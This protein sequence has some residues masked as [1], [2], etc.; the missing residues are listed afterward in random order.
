[1][2]VQCRAM[3]IKAKSKGQKAKGKKLDC[4]DGKGVPQHV[5]GDIAAD[6]G[7]AGHTLEHALEV[8][9]S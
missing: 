1:M 7:A 2:P 6:A 8:V 4:R 9:G 3:A 5:R